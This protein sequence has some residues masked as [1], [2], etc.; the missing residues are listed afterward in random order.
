MPRLVSRLSPPGTSWVTV[1]LDPSSEPMRNRAPEPSVTTLAVTPSAAALMES[2]MSL[3]PS[4]ALTATAGPMAPEAL[5][6]VRVAA[7]AMK[8]GLTT[9]D[10]WTLSVLRST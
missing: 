3:S 5:R 6:K 4:P 7:L 9:L 2:A 1:K 10:C 8:I